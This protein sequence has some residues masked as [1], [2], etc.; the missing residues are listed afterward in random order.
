[1][2]WPDRLVPAALNVTGK[3]NALVSFSIIETSFSSLALIT[4]F[5]NGRYYISREAVNNSFVTLD[6]KLFEF[7]DARTQSLSIQKIGESKFTCYP[8]PVV[9]KITLNSDQKIILISFFDILGK[10]VLDKKKSW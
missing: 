10:V 9:D 1:M 7:S 3:F 4:S 5:G 2:A 6:Q 8:N